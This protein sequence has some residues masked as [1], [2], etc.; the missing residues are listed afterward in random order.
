MELQ[1][2]KIKYCS[3]FPSLDYSE[4]GNFCS[5]QKIPSE[6]IITDINVSGSFKRLNK[7]GRI[8]NHTI[9][10]TIQRRYSLTFFHNSTID[11]SIL[12]VSD[13]LILTDIENVEFSLENVSVKSSSLT[14]GVWQTIIEC[15][16]YDLINE[17]C[18]LSSDFVKQKNQNDINQLVNRVEF[19][20]LKPSYTG[21][22]LNTVYA[23]SHFEFTIKIN[24]TNDN[25]EVGDK[26]YLH[27]DFDYE[28]M[29]LDVVEIILKTATTITFG[30]G[31]VPFI[32]NIQDKHFTLNYEP[33]FSANVG[34]IPRSLTTVI[35]TDFEPNLSVVFSDFGRSINEVQGKELAVGKI[36]SEK[37]TVPL[38][39]NDFD[40]WK[41]KE[42]YKADTIK[43]V[44][45]NE[46][47][48]QFGNSDFIKEKGN[49][50]L[51]RVKEY[52]LELTYNQE[53]VSTN[54]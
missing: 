25:L 52:T 4:D 50:N 49:N 40:Y 30:G 9:Q 13:N 48:Y 45:Q 2:I 17:V 10:S 12:Q 53:V 41:I 19:V 16:I 14:G 28:I 51:Y 46:T 27:S 22:I 23:G 35:Y 31:L 15:T 34:V 44:G 3:L 26:L 42:L 37:L 7:K 29:G 1:N 6:N 47:Y 21:F 11:T 24:S 33:V 20:N 38:I 32:S 43:F 8:S 18:N 39:L 36:F 54:H 5:F